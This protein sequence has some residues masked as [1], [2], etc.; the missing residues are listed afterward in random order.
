MYLVL[1]ELKFLDEF[2]VRKERS[3]SL[4]AI[5]INQLANQLVRHFLNLIAKG[6][7]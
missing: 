3:K 5:E 4:I 6:F 2:G 7:I 1:K